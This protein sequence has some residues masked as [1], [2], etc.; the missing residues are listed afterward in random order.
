MPE[1]GQHSFAGEMTGMRPWLGSWVNA[2]SGL[3][4][5]VGL[6][7]T[8]VG[9]GFIAYAP[10]GHAYA[11]TGIIAAFLASILGSLVPALVRGSGPMFGGPR[12]AQTLIFAALLGSVAGSAAAGDLSRVVMVA[13]T[14]LT[15]AGLLQM[16]FGFL[17]LGRIIRFT[18]LP[19]LAGFTNG[20]ALSMML[21]ALLII[22]TGHTESVW[23]GLE[24]ADTLARLALV[25][26]LLLLMARI[27][28]W[29]PMLHWSLLG[30]LFGSLL[31]AA[32]VQFMPGSSLGGML[33][34]VTSLHPASG[35]AALDFSQTVHFDWTDDL[36]L[37]LAPAVS[38]ATLNSLESLII[39]TQ[40]DVAHGTRHDSRR[41]LFG[42][43][44]ANVV[45]GLFGALPTAP[46][47]SRRLVARQMG[48]QAWS[49]SITFA[50]AM[51]ALLLMTPLFVSTIPK[52]A[53]AA[54]LLYMAFS[55]IDPWAKNQI[56]GLL[57]KEGNVEFQS[58]LRSNLW[59]M[60][61][62]M[63]VAVTVN[64]VAAMAVG[65]LLSMMLF[66]RHN[67]RSIVA[68]VY[69]G[70]KRRSAVMRP[71]AHNE[72]L[73]AQGDRIILVELAGPLFFGSGELLMDEIEGLA[74]KASQF[75]LDFRQVGTI[76]ASGAGA[77]QRIARHLQ[78]R[79]VRLLLSSISPTGTRGRMIREANASNAVADDCW[80]AD[81]DQAL[82]AAEDA[83]LAG[84]PLPEP[85]STGRSLNLDALRGLDDNQIAIFL[86][87]T[88]ENTY[89]CGEYLFRRNDP[90]DTLYLLLA[91]QVEIRIP[92]RGGPSKRLIALR[93][94][95]LFGEMAI[96]RGAPR[97]AD[98]VATQDKTELLSLAHVALDRMHREHPDIAL[99]FMRNIGVQLSARLASVTEELRYALSSNQ[100]DLPWP[101]TPPPA[102][103][104]E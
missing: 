52:I 87:Y 26:L 103:P 88:E 34:S 70:N 44:L 71:A 96:L 60:L 93:A 73:N 79:R 49:A 58:Q 1:S 57:R 7:A 29:L 82:E 9:Y 3:L 46:S 30:L 4:A 77:I 83:M 97:S 98:A 99:T 41:V 84:N 45:C 43:G 2:H 24:A 31:H 68:R 102:P 81:P 54:V 19:V 25:A 78:Q 14:C 95:T 38:L 8:D 51:L 65:V 101:P 74:G 33:P 55:I 59:V 16:A 100:Q 11:N 20:V 39:A 23:Q 12:P 47:N 72:M 53:V 21:S 40:Q 92:V 90:G 28:R 27:Y 104:G 17:G 42:Q 85:V 37:V 15:F 35:L 36:F 6:F 50:L 62:V 63:T 91:G 56:R 10:L 94:G 61:A 80:F 75:I 76:D 48:G 22:F 89:S 5:A 32:L 67:S 69:P 13:I 18:P 86:E 66:V 64:L